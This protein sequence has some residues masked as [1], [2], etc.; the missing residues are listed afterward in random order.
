MST[1][2]ISYR[3]Q[4]TVGHAGRIYDRLVDRYG[5]EGVYRDVDSGQL[6]EDFAE[7]IR[8]KV[9]A[10]GVLLALI[11]P[12][13]LKAT[14]DTGGWRLAHDHDFVRI[15]IST[16]LERGIRVIPVL[17]Q[18][19]TMPRAGDLPAALSKL[20]HRNAVEIRDSHFDQDVSQLIAD[21]SP[22]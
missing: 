4:D 19:A 5:S 7:T 18:G 2:F 3:R 6:G 21:L 14:D 22:P 13:W 10:C 9:E 12:A 20:S 15:E 17:L 16:A 11:G 8:S 1:V